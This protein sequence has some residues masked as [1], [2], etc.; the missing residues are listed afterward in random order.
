ME[1]VVRDIAADGECFDERA[2][3]GQNWLAVSPYAQ[4]GAENSNHVADEDT[5]RARFAAI[6]HAQMTYSQ[7]A[8]NVLKESCFEVIRQ[9]D[10]AIVQLQNEI[11]RLEKVQHLNAAGHNSGGTG[12]SPPSHMSNSPN[13]KKPQVA[14]SY[15]VNDS[16]S[17]I[18]R[19]VAN[20]KLPSHSGNPAAPPNRVVQFPDDDAPEMMALPMKMPDDPTSIRRASSADSVASDEPRP[21]ERKRSLADSGFRTGSMTTLPLS[22]VPP[23]RTMN[24]NSVV[25]S[26]KLA[27]QQAKQGGNT[28]EH[29]KA[30]QEGPHA[31]FIDATAMK[32]KVKE[33]VMRPE[34]NVMNFYKTEGIAQWLARHHWFENVTLSVIAFNA[35]WIAVDTDRNK[36]PTLVV[37][38][39]VFIVAEN[40]FCIYFTTEV[41]IRF[42]A[43]KNKHN[44]LRDAWF[45]F[46]SALVIMMVLETWV[47]SAVLILTDKGGGADLGNASILRLVRLLRL[48][49]MARMARLLRAMPELMI[50]IKG[51]SVATRSVFFTLCL[52]TIIIY[53]F[54]VA[55]AQLSEDTF[56]ED[57]YFPDVLT[58]MSS[59]LL[60]GVLPDLYEFVSVCGQ[61][62]IAFAILV[63]FFVLL[64]SL[65]VMNMLVGVL[66]EVVSV[67]SSVEKEQ[68]TV[69]FVKTM[70]LAMLQHSGI[71]ADR[72]KHISRPEFESLLLKPE[73]ARIIQE[74]GVD[75]VGL[76][77]FADFIFKDGI[78][79]TFA[80]FM[81]VVLQLRGSNT[82]TVR[83]IVD[84]RKFVLTQLSEAVGNITSLVADNMNDIVKDAM[85]TAQMNNMLSNAASN[86]KN[87]SNC[88]TS[89]TGKSN[90]E[91]ANVIQG[92]VSTLEKK[93]VPITA[94]KRCLSANAK[95]RGNSRER[96]VSSAQ[97]KGAGDVFRPVLTRTQSRI[98]T[99]TASSRPTSGTRSRPWSG[100]SNPQ[101]LPAFPD[102]WEVAEYSDDATARDSDESFQLRSHHRLRRKEL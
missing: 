36:A 79:L 29:Q 42:F 92:M 57:E 46:D 32:E 62:H 89:P 6:S 70:L 97:S 9:K 71:D 64:S 91:E 18:L 94:Q 33:A 99:A 7:H 31:V 96:P 27:R 1:T 86:E 77:D 40:F 44:C 16:S 73:A 50:L 14:W 34:Y 41:V 45:V 11:L 75:V 93:S 67:V 13:N 12:E 47:M 66:V 90:L 85:F 76:V 95:L 56:L 3:Q 54:S 28:G 59:L 84:L 15:D 17:S 102:S 8:L 68:M 78:E 55:F 43:F 63:L 26:A 30:M 101:P 4:H 69:Q 58:S 51:I 20:A 80:E 72:N 100:V 10:L 39:P 24:R 48:T 98:P 74:V 65:T 49:R 61:E 60:R 82:A 52:L 87:D 53:I 83:D 81:E 19:D 88:I 23:R 25:A 2:G 37:A 22:E 38:H 35:L 21:V 5:L